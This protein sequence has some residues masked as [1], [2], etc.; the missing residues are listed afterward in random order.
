MPKRT[1]ELETGTAGSLRHAPGRER[2]LR[3]IPVAPGIVL[4]TIHVYDSDELSI[5]ET[6]IAPDTVEKEVARLDR[7]IDDTRR[8]LT[9]L[10]AKI[11][12]QAGKDFA[13]FVERPGTV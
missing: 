12:A 7:A 8:E 10:Q 13:E 2:I 3:G 6:P 4:G 11:K 5:P 9:E 1:E